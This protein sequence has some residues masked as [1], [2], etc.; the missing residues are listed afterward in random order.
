[1]KGFLV[2][3]AIFLSSVSSV[4]AIECASKL[5][6]VRS[7]HWSYRNID[8]RKCWYQGKPMLPKSSLHWPKSSDDE[9]EAAT[10]ATD[11]GPTTDG[12]NVSAPPAADPNIWP[13]PVLDET[14]FESRWQALKPRS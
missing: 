3:G 4:Q 10:P 13:T 11:V 14:S 2:F 6:A 8:G 9:A 12:R 1:M 7:G 5:P